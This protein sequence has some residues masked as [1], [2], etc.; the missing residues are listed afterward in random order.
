[1]SL[2]VITTTL[3]C[4]DHLTVTIE[5]V[6]AFRSLPLS[7]VIVDGGSTD[8]TVEVIRR[9]AAADPRIRWISEPDRGIYDAMNK[10]WVLAAPE[11]RVLFLGGGDR[12]VS[13]PDPDSLEGGE[14]IYGDVLIGRRLFKG[15]AGWGL[16]LCN[17]LHHQALLVPR[18]LHPAPP[19]DLRFRLYADFDFNQRLLKQGVRFRYDPLLRAA[20][21]PGGVSSRKD[22]REMLAVVRK[23]FGVAWWL[24]ALLFLPVRMMTRLVEGKG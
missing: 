13:L 16:R 18:A 2:A 15:G 6:Q 20:A 23:N 12:L 24:A 5:S 1:M 17:T 10:G 21:L 7:H 3:N 9:Y 8:G 11:S 22:R 4:R 19:F 14:V